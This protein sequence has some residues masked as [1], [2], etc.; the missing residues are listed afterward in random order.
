MKTKV[1][2]AIASLTFSIILILAAY[3][4]FGHTFSVG[5][6]PLLVISI[7][8]AAPM[9]AYGAFDYVEVQRIYSAEKK[10]P[11][12]LRDLSNYTSFGVPLSQAFQRITANNYDYLTAGV[13]KV[14]SL[15]S[16]GVGFE[17]AVSELKS[18]VN[19][20][21]IAMV[22]KILQKANESGSNTSD[23]IWIL[24][25]FTT[26]SELLKESR[27]AEMKN[28]NLVM[29]ISFAVF[30]FVILFLDVRFLQVMLQHGLATGSFIAG[31][32]STGNIEEAFSVGVLTQA[33]AIGIISGILRD[34]RFGTG[35]LLS[36]ILV[37]V[38]TALFVLLG[39][40]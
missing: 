1:L 36:G 32:F 34:V 20:A 12:L 14:S 17:E 31:S 35:I 6:D 23:V 19:S 5:D 37:A 40:Y 11:D 28:F 39:V 2:A 22:S 21:K 33:I 4:Y 7:A 16:S 25:E 29:I 27:V 30:L 38:S 15:V 26:Q 3:F 9:V 24:S 8:L 18:G 13:R 10:L